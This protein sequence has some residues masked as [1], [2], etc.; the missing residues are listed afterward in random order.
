MVEGPAPAD[1]HGGRTRRPNFRADKSRGLLLFAWTP[2][3]S[4]SISPPVVET[5]SASGLASHSSQIT[6]S[7]QRSLLRPS[8]ARA[9]RALRRCRRAPL[10]VCF[11]PYGVRCAHRARAAHTAARALE[12]GSL[13]TPLPTPSRRRRRPRHRRRPR[14]SVWECDWRRQ[15]CRPR[16][17]PLFLRAPSLLIVQS[18]WFLAAGLVLKKSLFF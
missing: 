7:R 1:M 17:W 4:S 15:K 14:C 16:P 9:A 11:P 2:F 13:P 6:S 3:A 10:A 5:E 12:H 18:Q 8:V